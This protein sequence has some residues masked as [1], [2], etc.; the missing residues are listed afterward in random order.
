MNGMVTI[1]SNNKNLVLP[2]NS[3]FFT[4]DNNGIILNQGGYYEIYF[5]G[6]LKDN[7]P[8]DKAS[9][10]LKLYD[11]NLIVIRLNSENQSYFSRTI[12]SQCDSLQKVT[13]MF[14]KQDNATASA[15]AVYLLIKKLYF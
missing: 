7:S 15:E 4:L 13:I 5:Y 2:A 10:T 8:T 3:N 9:L 11:D 14:Q 6:L 12:V 1:S